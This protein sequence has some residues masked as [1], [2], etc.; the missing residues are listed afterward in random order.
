MTDPKG[1]PRPIVIDAV[2]AEVEQPAV[3]A[4]A[5]QLCEHLGQAS[6]QTWSVNLRWRQDAEAVGRDGA[7]DVTLIS[8]LPE[9]GHDE[10][11]ATVEARL[12]AALADLDA[13][14]IGPVYL[15]TVFRHTGP[16]VALTVRER[17][18][19]LNQLVITLSH[20]AGVFVVDLDRVL[21]H[22]GG[23]VVETDF[24]LSGRKAAETAG[25]AIVSAILAGGL[26][27]AVP[28][29]VQEKAIQLN[30]SLADIG[31]IVGRRLA[32]GA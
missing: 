4:A 10:P 21:A 1:A 9:L 7:P 32:V 17:I 30:G 25:F 27:E 11:I 22:V 26:D 28:P 2:I 5:Q 18:R 12:R 29:Q 13:R 16:D 31:R 23:A 8:M 15:G 3:L 24:R 14:G 20:D 19:R 6:G